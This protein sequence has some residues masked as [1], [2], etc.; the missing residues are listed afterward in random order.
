MNGA[1]RVAHVERRSNPA[2]VTSPRAPLTRGVRARTVRSPA[3]R[4]RRDAAAGRA[5]HGA[6]V[7][8]EPPPRWH[9]DSAL[10]RRVSGA[11]AQALACAR[12]AL[13]VRAAE[14][15]H[16]PPRPSVA[17]R[18][19]PQAGL[20]RGE[21]ARWGGQAVYVLVDARN[22]EP[23]LEP[24][25]LAHHGQDLLEQRAAEVGGVGHDEMRALDERTGTDE[26]D[27]GRTRISDGGGHAVRFGTAQ[28]FVDTGDDLPRIDVE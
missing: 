17:L 28:R 25:D 3:R 16:R 9:G 15:E 14:G 7:R 12:S 20:A 21:T 22:V 4:E 18:D 11:V 5:R 6:R 2:S 8:P 27:A 10:S 13:T 19:Q 23:P 26:V 24:R 1:L